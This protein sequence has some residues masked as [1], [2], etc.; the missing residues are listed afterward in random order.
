MQVVLEAIKFNHDPNSATA[1]AFNIR[2]NETEVVNVPEWRRVISVKPEDSP[3]AYARDELKGRTPTIRVKFSFL[4]FDPA[5]QSIKIRALDGHLTPRMNSSESSRL[6]VD[7]LT[8]ALRHAGLDN[9]LGSVVEREISLDSGEEYELFHLH[10]ARISS[11]G[12]SASDIIWRWQYLTN[13]TDWIDFATTTHRVFT[14][15]AM[16]TSPWQPESY[17][18]SNTQQPWAEVLDYACRWAESAT[19]VGQ[20]AKLVTERVYELGRGLVYYDNPS[21]GNTSFT[22]DSPYSFDCTDFLLLLRGQTNRHGP[23]VNCDDCSAFVASFANILGSRLSEAKMERSFPLHPHRLIGS[24]LEPK[25]FSYHSVAWAGACSEDD[26]VF[27]A[28]LQLDSDAKPEKEPHLW[29]TPTN[30]RFGRPGEQLYRFRLTSSEAKCR[31]VQGSAIHRRIGFTKIRWESA[32]SKVIAISTANGLGKD[33]IRY[34]FDRLSLLASEEG[35]SPWLL[36]DFDFIDDPDSLISVQSFWINRNTADV[37]LQ[38]D[39]HV[40]ATEKTASDKIQKLFSRF[41]LPDIKP[42]ENPDFGSILYTVPEKFVVLFGRG[43]FVFRL[44]NIGKTVVSC[45]SFARAIDALLLGVQNS[46]G[47]AIPLEGGNG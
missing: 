27:D 14:V 18:N 21:S 42:Q 41:Q 10:D 40:S 46:P 28:C 43:S 17:E 26:E 44:R 7:L 24:A 47:Q 34:V 31:P 16:P 12:V 35:V 3:A 37:A 5:I 4:D 29:F 9:V 20:A 19:H 39:A 15:L 36:S 2:R 22:I 13:S 30:L 32:I 11:A 6:L 38:I 1:D 33:V 23:G 25:E 8:L 45:E